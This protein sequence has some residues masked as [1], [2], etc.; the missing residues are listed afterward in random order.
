MVIRV[1]YFDCPTGLAGD[2]CLA[3][4]VDAGVPLDYIDRHLRGLGLGNEY[5]LTAQQIRSNGQRATHITVELGSSSGLDAHSDA[6]PDR[7][8]PQPEHSHKPLDDP[9]D[10]HPNHSDLN[11]TLSNDLAHPLHSHSHTSDNLAHSKSTHDSPHHHGHT[12]HLPEIEQMIEAASLP[13]RVKQ[14]S[15]DIFRKLAQAEGAVHGIAPEEVHFHEVGATDAI[16]D[17]VG[18][19]LGLDWLNID[20][21]YC[22]ALP[23]GGGTVW[24]AH[25]RLPVPAPAVLK[26]FELRHVPIY[27]N[28]IECELVTPTGAAIATT[29]ATAFGPPPAMTLK[30]VGLGAGSLSLPLPNVVRLWL[31]DGVDERADHK[32]E[33]RSDS[34]M[35]S[36]R[37]EASG[38]IQMRTPQLAPETSD[39]SPA[40]VAAGKIR[41]WPDF[42]SPD[43]AEAHPTLH[44]A[45]QLLKSTVAVLETQ[46]DDLSPQAIGH[47]FT[48]LFAVGALDVLTQPVGMKKCRPGVLLTVICKPEHVS[49][50]ESAIFRETTTLGI[51]CRLDCRSE[52]YRDIQPIQTVYGPVRLKLGRMAPQGPVINVQP[53]YED[54][55]RQAEAAGVSWL[56]VHQMAIATYLQEQAHEKSAY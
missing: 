15:V 13:S 51:R 50:C 31:G 3:A 29:L 42:E 14:W 49:D 30:R 33:G 24:A 5:R 54:C 20:R 10:L 32:S 12:R 34:D 40:A 56:Q 18:T 6:Q 39:V 45:D 36:Q 53:E 9:D 7:V 27:S 35:S 1:A 23:T 37:L 4:L 52:L 26:L 8:A 17:V 55:V 38:S 46:I 19:C 47:L 28:G 21:I 43:N 44:R 2:M 48:V 16:V 22:S 41:Q 11:A 25:G